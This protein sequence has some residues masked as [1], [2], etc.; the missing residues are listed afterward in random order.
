M[1]TALVKRDLETSSNPTPPAVTGHLDAGPEPGYDRKGISMWRRLEAADV[2]TGSPAG[3]WL[4]FK[5]ELN[6]FLA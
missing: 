5:H 1:N 4:D 6:L 3:T 2:E